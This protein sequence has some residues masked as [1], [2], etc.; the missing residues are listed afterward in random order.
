MPTKS[1]DTELKC[2]SILCCYNI[3]ISINIKK[4]NN[5]ND[6]YILLNCTYMHSRHAEAICE[7]YIMAVVLKFQKHVCVHKINIGC[8]RTEN[9]R[10]VSRACEPCTHC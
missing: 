10:T 4:N 7:I 3:Y 2:Y 5:V 1:L 9:K 8:N 6:F